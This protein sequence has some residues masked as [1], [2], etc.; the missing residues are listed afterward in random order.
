L[1]SVGYY[2]AVVGIIVAGFSIVSLAGEFAIRRTQKSSQDPGWSGGLSGK[3]ITIEEKSSL[4][5]GL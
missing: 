5:S 1:N 2:I 3:R 4:V